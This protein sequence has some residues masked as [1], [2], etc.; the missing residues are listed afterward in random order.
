MRKRVEIM[1]SENRFAYYHGEEPKQFQFYMIPKTL[2]DNKEFTVSIDAK[3]MYSVMLDRASLSYKNGWIDE[4]NRVYIIFTIDKVQEVLDCS[5]GKA[6]KVLQEL[7]TEKGIGLIER[8]KSTGMGKPDIIYVKDFMTG[9]TATHNASVGNDGT[10][11]DHKRYKNRTTVEQVE[12]EKV[13]AKEEFS[14][15]S[16]VKSTKTVDIVGKSAVIHNRKPTE[17]QNLDLSGTKIEPIEVQNLDLSG[18]KFRPIE[19]QKVNPNKTNNNNTEI[20]HTESS[21]IKS[22]QKDATGQDRTEC[23]SESLTAKEIAI[24]VQNDFLAEGIL[25]YRYTQPEYYRHLKQAVHQLTEYE[26]AKMYVEEQHDLESKK[27]AESYFSTIH[28]FNQ[29]LIELLSSDRNH[30][31]GGR[32]VTYAKVYDQLVDHIVQNT[33]PSGR[34]TYR[35]AELMGE[36]INKYQDATRQTGVVIQ[37]PTA[38][39]MTCILT[40]MENGSARVFD[41]IRRDFG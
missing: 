41:V 2:I 32:V 4:E 17:V 5:K 21:H 35:I 28:I 39:M 24:A 31:V 30:K 8:K 33:L 15:E 10:N 22:S 23:V 27:Q 37:R 14:V 7:D 3:F 36:A 6:V 12:S 13:V 9:T 1:S 25:P 26:K 11:H 19:V 29:A 38:Y 18:T 16:A 40:A 34:T 20:N